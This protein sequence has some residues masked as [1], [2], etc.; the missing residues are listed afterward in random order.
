MFEKFR[1]PLFLVTALG[2]LSASVLLGLY[3]WI[4]REAGLPTLPQLR[5]IHVHM[6]LVGGVAQMIFGAMLTFIPPLLMVP[7]EEKKSRA[8]QYALL[9]GG[10]LGILIGFG[11]SNFP[12]IG[13]SGAAVGLVF[14]IL[15][16]DVIGMVK[17]S[18]QRTGLNLWFYG[19]AVLALFAGIGLA[20]LIAFGAFQPDATNLARLAHLHL[21]LMGFVTLTIVGTMHNLFPTVAGSRLYSDRLAVVAFVTLPLGIAALV[22]GFIFAEPL[23]QM[24]AGFVLLTGAVCYGWNIFRT[25]LSAETKFTLPVLHLLCATGWLA[26]T[27]AA[28][29]FLAWNSRTD[30]PEFPTGTA[31][32]MGY[33]HMALVGFILQTI[34]GALSHLLPVILTLNRVKSQK[35]RR[36]Y[37]DEL[38]RLI[39][40]GK[41]IQLAALNLGVA[42]MMGWGL[43]AGFFGLQAGP[44]VAAV[45][46]SAALLLIG[47]GLFAGKIVRL[48][49]SHPQE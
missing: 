2:W 26:L 34:M 1:P 17:K 6:A 20:E 27:M 43:S 23:F 31:H 21:N 10:T 48:L 8:F 36:P 30:P 5:V 40:R 41:W 39:E 47:L 45:W 7:F 46:I 3:V 19:L 24:I 22:G 13:M 38:I 14:L 49:A 44:T 42:G 18:V 33:S 9:N 37:L 16:S 15:F 28:G 29:I 11:I 35:K 25:W 4:A 32:M 12:L